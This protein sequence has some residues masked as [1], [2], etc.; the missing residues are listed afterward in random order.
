M[1]L[2]EAELEAVRGKIPIYI[3]VRRL[4][5]ETILSLGASEGRVQLLA[6]SLHRKEN[7]QAGLAPLVQVK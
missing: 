3:I 4:A 2:Y 6:I 5:K 1:Y 7:L